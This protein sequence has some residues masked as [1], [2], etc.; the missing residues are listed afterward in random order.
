[1]NSKTYT[2]ERRRFFR[3]DDYINLYYK[4]IDESAFTNQL[5]HVS[6]D[7]LQSCSLST[8]LEMVTQEARTILRRI[9]HTDPEIA[10]YL[11]VLNTKIDLV[12]QAFLAQGTGKQEHKSHNVNLSASGLAFDCAEHLPIDAYLEL[13][14]VLSSYTA[15]VVLYGKVVYCRENKA[16]STGDL[17]Y[18]VGVDYVNLQEEDREL[19]IKHIF[20]RQMQQIRE[21][22]E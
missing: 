3:I 11:A 7:I 6:T 22:R 15:V 13:R 8:A 18:M 19:L 2:D 5:S 4:V 16:S 1:M 14:V 10:E 17:P 9:E 21:S 20:K 12:A